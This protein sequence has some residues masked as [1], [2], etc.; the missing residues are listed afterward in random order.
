M[1]S[2]STVNQLSTSSE[3]LLPPTPTRVPLTRTFPKH[4]SRGEEDGKV[5]YYEVLGDPGTVNNQQVRRDDTRHITGDERLIKVTPAQRQELL[6]RLRYFAA[7][8]QSSKAFI[9]PCPVCG[10][11]YKR[12]SYNSNTFVTN[13][14]IQNPAGRINVPPPIRWSPGYNVNDSSGHWYR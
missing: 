13:M 5:H 11:A 9:H 4:T 6:D 10:S 1:G 7:Y 12:L 2:D 8:D 3:N 14:L